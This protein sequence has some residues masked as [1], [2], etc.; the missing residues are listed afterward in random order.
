MILYLCDVG[1]NGSY[2]VFCVLTFV[3]I[4]KAYKPKEKY[5]FD[6]NGN[7][8]KLQKWSK[9]KCKKAIVKELRNNINKNEEI[10]HEMVLQLQDIH[11]CMISQSVILLISFVLMIVLLLRK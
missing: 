6:P 1:L 7:W 5:Q 9:K 4:Y 10:N 11:F 8:K 2:V 3:K